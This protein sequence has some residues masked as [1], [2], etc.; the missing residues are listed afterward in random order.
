MGRNYYAHD[1]SHCGR[2]AKVI[3]HGECPACYGYRLKHA[4][5]AR[6]FG[7]DGGPVP[8]EARNLRGPRPA[9]MG[10]RHPRWIGDRASPV[11]GRQRAQRRYP[12]LGI[13]VRC[14]IA[15]A[16]ARHHRDRDTGNNE[17]E[18]LAFLCD[19]CH[20]RAHAGD[21][22]PAPPVPCSNCGRPT[23]PTR[24]GRCYACY[25]H[26]RRYGRERVT[27]TAST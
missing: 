26:W 5:A 2:P 11:L 19:P 4:G 6:P 17:P 15:P 10:D 24:R 16:T 12:E 9:I 27:T 1:C 14:G 8:I 22:V 18:N 25:R 7:A 21:Q 3:T 13:C 23:K 20:H